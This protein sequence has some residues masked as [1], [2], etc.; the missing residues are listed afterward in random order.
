MTHVGRSIAATAVFA[1]LSVWLTWPQVAVLGDAIVGGP[2]A[3]S[4]GWQNVW[5]LWWLRTALVEGRSPFYTD[6]LFWPYGVSLGFQALGLTNGLLALPVLLGSG[7]VAAYGVAALLNV[8]LS[9][10]AVYLLALRVAGSWSAA[11]LAGICAAAAPAHMARFLDGQLEHVALQWLALYFLALV[12]ASERPTARI[13]LA[14]GAAAALVAY[15]SMYHAL[16]AALCTAVWVG[17]DLIATRRPWPALRPWLVAAPLAAALLL[18]ALLSSLS[19][20]ADAKRDAAHWRT[21]AELSSVDLIEVVLPS[22]HHPAWG[23]EVGEYQE[24]LRANRGVA[25][26]APGLVTLAL[27][28]AGLALRRR[29]AARWT[30]LAAVL[31]LF[32][33]GARLRVGG[34]DTGVPLPLAPLLGEV[35]GLTFGYR[36]FLAMNAAV[37]PIAVLAALGAEA[38][39]SRSGP[40]TW[41]ALGAALAAGVLIEGA[42]PPP[43]L[44]RDDTPAIYAGLR[45]G[46]GAL[47]ALPV[48]LVSDLAGNNANLR[49]Q[50]AH[51]RPIIGGY[52]ARPPR[53]PLASA[54]LIGQLAG[55]SCEPP[56]IVRDDAAVGRSALSFYRIDRVVLDAGRMTGTQRR[57]ADELLRGL[58]GLEAGRSQGAIEVFDIPP[59]AAE[60]FVYPGAGWLPTENAGARRWR[61]LTEEGILYLVNTGAAPET[62][63]L[64]LHLESYARPR[65]LRLELDGQPIGELTVQPNPARH[66]QVLVRVAPGEHEIRLQAPTDPTPELRN[67]SVAAMAIEIERMP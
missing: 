54:P 63:A 36:R 5:N 47:M 64:R 11:V 17:W 9:A 57:C 49:A 25:T 37:V 31:L 23:E 46:E 3:A 8:L 42:P 61:W 62:F 56:G 29:E 19:G 14:L 34:L 52:V 67:V 39:R 20:L 66:Y 10:V 22:A 38:L 16:F 27:A 48:S 51:G 59:A 24:G 58:L 15:T 2:I 44:L 50:M 4:D 26:V 7:P 60:P 13:G 1:G 65:P 33:L 28:A 41:P 32:A 18:P 53:Y 45:Q 55:R 6:L 12:H 35:P 43:G 40:R 30:A 21:Q